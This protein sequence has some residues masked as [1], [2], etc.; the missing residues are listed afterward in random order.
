LHVESCRLSVFG[1]RWSFRQTQNLADLHHEGMCKLNHP[2]SSQR[3][4]G[5]TLVELLV[6]MAVVAV[7]ASVAVPS[8]QKFVTNRAVTARADELASSLRLARSEALKRG[9]AVSVC[10]SGSPQ[11]ANPACSGAAD[12]AKGWL[13]F[14]D[15]NLNGAIDS[16]QGEQVLATHVP[17]ASVKSLVAKDGAGVA[18]AFT[19]F[20]PNG[21]A[22]AGSAVFTIEPNISSSDSGYAAAHRRVEHNL[23]GRVQVLAGL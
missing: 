11:A 15:S 20:H 2:S 6:V 21:I 5:F 10:A 4:Q 17:Q 18:R 13:V 9:G 7:L 12:W 1:F 22:A 14:T 16:A 23:Q 19:G 8:L 3:Q